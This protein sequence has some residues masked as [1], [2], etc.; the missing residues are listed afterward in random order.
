MVEEC[1]LTF[2]WDQILRRYGN[3]PELRERVFTE[4]EKRKL[5]FVRCTVERSFEHFGYD[6]VVTATRKPL[7][8]EDWSR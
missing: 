4:L 3:L 8:P 7:G 6:V 2:R 1:T 5:L